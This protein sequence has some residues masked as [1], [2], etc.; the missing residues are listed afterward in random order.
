MKPPMALLR[1]DS[2]L[3]QP[4]GFALDARFETDAGVTALVGPSGSGKTTILN[5][6]AGVLRPDDGVIRLADHDLV[7]TRRGVWLPPE[8]RRIGVVFQDHLLFPHLTVRKN[9][10]FGHGRRDCR[11]SRPID[12][13][14]VVEVLEIADLVDRMP[15]T[16]SG[17][18]K[19]RVALGRALLRSPDLLLM[20]EPFVALH[21]ELKE[22]IVIYLERVVAEWRVPVLLVS[23]AEDEVLRLASRT[24][25]VTSGRIQLETNEGR[26]PAT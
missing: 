17:G 5:L 2:R 8:R 3:Q 22:R 14:R 9:L 11:S 23:H 21:Q 18:Q 26:A 16:L 25:R 13:R 15:A 20:D 10:M 19:Q 24:Y 1:F 4:S 12:L 6:I 7:D